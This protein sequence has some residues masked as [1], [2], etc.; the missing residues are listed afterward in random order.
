MIRKDWKEAVRHLNVAA[1]AYDDAVH[2]VPDFPEPDPRGGMEQGAPLV[3]TRPHDM[4][5]FHHENLG[6]AHLQRARDLKAD[7]CIM[8]KTE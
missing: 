7:L 1:E 4:Q 5:T 2:I 8:R 6:M 3:Q